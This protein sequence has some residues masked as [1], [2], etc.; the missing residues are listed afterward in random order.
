MGK[1]RVQEAVGMRRQTEAEDRRKAEQQE[2]ALFRTAPA[3]PP[4]LRYSVFPGFGHLVASQYRQMFF[5][6]YASILPQLPKKHKLR[7]KPS[8]A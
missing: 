5:F 4:G 7:R 8:S 3:V 1:A 6:I 2:P